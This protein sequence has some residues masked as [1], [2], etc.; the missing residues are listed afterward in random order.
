MKF[1]KRKWKFI[2][3]AMSTAIIAAF[4]L[5]FGIGNYFCAPRQQ[6]VGDFP[7]DLAGENIEFSSDSG[8]RIHG[9][10]LPGQ[11]SHGAIILM[12]GIRGK[13]SDMLGHARFLNKAGYSVLLFDFQAHGE[14]VGQHITFGYLESEDAKAAVE[15]LRQKTPNEKVAVLGVSLG[16]AAATL[17]NPPLKVDAM[18]L[19]MVYPTIEQATA[20]RIA[21]VV[22]NFGKRF[23]PLL[24][25]QIKPRLGIAI[26]EL[27]PI[28]RVSKISAPKL[29]VAGTKD[30]HTTIAEAK[31]LFQTAS[32][33]KEFW[34]VEGA[35]HVDLHT[36]AREEYEKRILE[37]LRKNLN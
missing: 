1:L 20:D 19:E 12:H 14:S 15:Y 9:W 4:I 24:T 6:W 17:A 23:S 11:Q 36:Y 18:I 8:S 7:K 5:I 33:P 25:W 16:G 2:L 28:E 35:G 30:Q 32:S 22:G 3:I 10:F 34:A 13:R 37:F 26:N 29:F 21:I 27:R 31:N